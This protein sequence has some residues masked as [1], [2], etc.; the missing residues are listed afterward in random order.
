MA[1]SALKR[2]DNRIHGMGSPCFRSGIRRALLLESNL[3]PEP[4]TV[5]D[6]ICS[7]QH[8]Y[9]LRQ[10]GER[11]TQI[12]MSE[13][14]STVFAS[15]SYSDSNSQHLIK[16]RAQEADE[17]RSE[18]PETFTNA[19][20]KAWGRTVSLRRRDPITGN[21]PEHLNESGQHPMVENWHNGT[22]SFASKSSQNTAKD[23]EVE[24]LRIQESG[25]AELTSA[26]LTHMHSPR[27]YKNMPEEDIAQ[28][29]FSSDTQAQV[30]SM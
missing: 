24:M 10:K 23:S 16:K 4:Q 27:K 20:T 7:I 8:L 18:S 3:K 28:P 9:S 19:R 12:K 17:M 29:G 6:L 30:Y 11:E 15:L 5:S 25:N 2:S 21:R 1:L 26:K 13:E 14:L 22:T